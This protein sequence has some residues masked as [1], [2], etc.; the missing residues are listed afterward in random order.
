MTILLKRSSDGKFD[1]TFDNIKFDI[2]EGEPYSPE[3]LTEQVRSLDG[4]EV[5]LRGY[6]RPSFK[7]RDLKNFVFVRDDKECCFGPG[8]GV[9]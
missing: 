4:E 8:A 1:I 7:Q 6:I 9:V 5:K 3:M 2:P